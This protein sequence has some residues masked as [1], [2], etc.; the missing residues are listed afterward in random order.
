MSDR[1]GAKFFAARTDLLWGRMLAERKAQGDTEKARD[2]L[3]KAHT[4]AVVH[5]YGTVERRAAAASAGLG[6]S[7]VRQS[8]EP[9][10]PDCNRLMVLH[11][12]RQ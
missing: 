5:G 6:L 11:F 1:M 10:L 12:V 9:G 2:L 7:I 4:A 8:V 3:T